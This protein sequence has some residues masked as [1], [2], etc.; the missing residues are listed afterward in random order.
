MMPIFFK[1][2]NA[3]ESVLSIIFRLMAL[4]EHGIFYKDE[5]T[6]HLMDYEIGDFHLRNCDTCRNCWFNECIRSRSNHSFNYQTWYDSGNHTLTGWLNVSDINNIDLKSFEA[7]IEEFNIF[8]LGKKETF[9][10]KH[11]AYFFKYKWFNV[12]G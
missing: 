1:K 3:P 8:S 7:V 4:S 12:N 5:G 11:S 10:I 6:K 9:L 2:Y